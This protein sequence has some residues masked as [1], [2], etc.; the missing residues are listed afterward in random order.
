MTFLEQKM[1]K[2]TKKIQLIASLE[3]YYRIESLRNQ[4]QATANG[5]FC[6]AC[7][8]TAAEKQTSLNQNHNATFSNFS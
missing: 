3:V 8:F 7:F 5:L 4:Y 6:N 1:F 2:L